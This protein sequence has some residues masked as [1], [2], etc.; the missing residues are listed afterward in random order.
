MRCLFL[1]LVV[2]L[3]AVVIGVFAVNNNSGPDLRV[4]KSSPGVE[5]EFAKYKE[6]IGSDYEGYKN[7]VYRVLSYSLYFL[8]NDD[9]YKDVIE[10]A[11]V[12]HDIG[13]WTDSVLD[14]LD[15]S[16]E[17][18]KKNLEHV[19]NEEQ[20]QLVHDIIIYHHKITPFD[21]NLAIIVNAVRK[22]DWI[23]ASQG[24]VHQ[25]M[26]KANIEKAYKE[27]PAAGFY[28]TLADFGPRLHGNDFLTMIWE[29]K[30]IYFICKLPNLPN[31]ER[32]NVICLFRSPKKVE[33]LN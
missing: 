19:Y 8:N 29:M 25:G 24:F 33:Q 15:P 12:Y 9:T 1:L 30:K 14:Y 16:F 23:D 3:V 6:L 21:G 20:L 17:V 28:D 26:P 22:A 27:L 32:I 2:A 10:R 13:L 18:A 5:E 4:I 7:H 31:K 11:L